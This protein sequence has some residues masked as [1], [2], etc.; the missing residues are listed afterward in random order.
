MR[1]LA[2]KGQPLMR[3]SRGHVSRTRGHPPVATCL[4]SQAALPILEQTKAL[5]A[6]YASCCSRVVLSVSVEQGGIAFAN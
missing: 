2:Y 4:I 3:R 1:S 5:L 6:T